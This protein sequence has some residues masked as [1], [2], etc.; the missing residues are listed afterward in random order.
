MLSLGSGEGHEHVTNFTK[1]NSTCGSY[2]LSVGRNVPHVLW[3]FAI[4]FTVPTSDALPSL[5][6]EV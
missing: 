5:I 1:Q 3:N 6:N 2:Y 4:V